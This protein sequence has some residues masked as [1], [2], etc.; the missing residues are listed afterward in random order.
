MLL[1]K[2]QIEIEKENKNPQT[3][4]YDHENI[5]QTLK[6]KYPRRSTTI[7]LNVDAGEPTCSRY[8]NFDGF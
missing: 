3:S 7:F 2:N 4:A 5:E 1:K 8:L 6:I